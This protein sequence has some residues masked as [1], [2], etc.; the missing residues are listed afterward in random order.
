MPA[1]SKNKRSLKQITLRA[2]S[3]A[4][5]ASLFNA[6]FVPSHEMR[7]IRQLLRCVLVVA[8]YLL[9]SFGGIFMLLYFTLR[10]ELHYPR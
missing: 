9:M 2:N 4:S 1:Y 7:Y 10:F 5:Y 6:L 8:T 3:T